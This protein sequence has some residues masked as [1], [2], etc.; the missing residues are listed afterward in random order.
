MN[1]YIPKWTASFYT[2]YLY[3]TTAYLLQFYI[4]YQQLGRLTSITKSTAGC[5]KQVPWLLFRTPDQGMDT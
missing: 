4:S 3:A 1:E 2:N 5:A